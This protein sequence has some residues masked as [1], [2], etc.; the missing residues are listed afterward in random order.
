MSSAAFGGGVS[1]AGCIK[2]Q[3]PFRNKKHYFL[4]IEGSSSPS[5]AELHHPVKHLV[6]GISFILEGSS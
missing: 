4:P 5:T 3:N 2:I 6:G 1:L